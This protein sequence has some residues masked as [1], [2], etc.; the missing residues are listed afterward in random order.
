MHIL[1]NLLSN[2]EEYF[3]LPA[4]GDRLTYNQK[5]DTNLDYF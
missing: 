4:T 2:Y 1:Q 5:Q 3:T